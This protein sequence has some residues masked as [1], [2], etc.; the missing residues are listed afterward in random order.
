[1]IF[2]HV[3]H[4][5]QNILFVLLLFFWYQQTMIGSHK[6]KQFNHSESDL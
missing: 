2:F 1:V 3:N 4:I 5:W 6:T